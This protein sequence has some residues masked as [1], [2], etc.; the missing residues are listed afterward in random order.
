MTDIRFYHATRQSL[1]QAVLSIVG[2]AY[3]QDKR[4][5]ILCRDKKDMAMYDDLL[6]TAKPE[7]F[8]PHGTQD[9][10]YETRQPIY[11]TTKAH[12]PAN[13]DTL[14][15]CDVETAPDNVGDFSIVCDFIDGTN[16]D[17]IAHG[18]VRWKTYKDAGHNVTYWQQS[19][20][21]AWAQ[22]A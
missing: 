8:L 18:R 17:S 10:A 21:G 5:L 22:K 20:D 7:S 11:I 19:D 15:L 13:A 6:W 4:I 1:E 14:A 2:K 16:D 9:D 3:G 12:N